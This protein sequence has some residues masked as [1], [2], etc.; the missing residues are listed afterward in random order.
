MHAHYLFG[1][2]YNQTIELALQDKTKEVKMLPYTI[3][4]YSMKITPS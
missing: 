2:F 3:M 1:F 4:S